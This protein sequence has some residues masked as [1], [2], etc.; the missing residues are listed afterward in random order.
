MSETDGLF[1]LWR[2]VIEL[3]KEASEL[4]NQADQKLDK[5]FW[6]PFKVGK[7]LGQARQK[8]DLAKDITKTVRESSDIE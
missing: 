4:I 6:G 3:K 8:V 7:L 2:R 5:S 1:N